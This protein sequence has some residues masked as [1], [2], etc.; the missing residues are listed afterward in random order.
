MTEL[1][2]TS[3]EQALRAAL[4]LRAAG[5]VTMSEG[6]WSPAQA[7]HHLAASIECSVRGYPRLRPWIVRAIAGRLV[8]PRILRAGVLRHDCEAPVPGLDEGSPGPELGP[9]LDRLE[10]AGRDFLAAPKLAPH[11]VFGAIEPGAFARFHGLHLAD[12]LSRFVVDGR[13]FAAD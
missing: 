8:L 7:I 1:R 6:T 4:R 5:V 12:H 10:A 13:P 9:A 3:L 2:F 11:A